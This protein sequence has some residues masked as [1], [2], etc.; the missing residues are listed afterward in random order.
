[1]AIFSK[2]I[3]SLIFTFY[4]KITRSDPKLLNNRWDLVTK[5]CSKILTSQKIHQILLKL[6]LLEVKYIGENWCVDYSHTDQ[7]F[8]LFWWSRWSLRSL[9]SIFC[10]EGDHICGR[11]RFGTCIYGIHDCP[12]RICGGGFSREGWALW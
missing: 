2:K 6:M 7:V 10:R 1:M 9:W 11:V 12:C 4:H 5:E 8:I 3:N